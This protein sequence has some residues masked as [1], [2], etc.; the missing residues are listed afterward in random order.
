MTSENSRRRCDVD[1]VADMASSVAMSWVALDS[2]QGVIFYL[3][4]A[5]Y[6]ARLIEANLD[7]VIS[8]ARLERRW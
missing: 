8:R 3:N 1:V 5:G 7:R 2:S 6:S 4:T